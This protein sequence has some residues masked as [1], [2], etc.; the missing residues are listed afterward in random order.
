MRREQSRILHL[1]RQLA[2]THAAGDGTDDG[3]PADG[4]ELRALERM[5]SLTPA[6]SIEDACVQIMLVLSSVADIEDHEEREKSQRLLWSALNA[7]MRGSEKDMS[8]YGREFYAPAHL[9][10]WERSPEGFGAAVTAFE[11]ATRPAFPRSGPLPADATVIPF[12]TPAISRSGPMDVAVRRLAVGDAA[13]WQRN[14]LAE[15]RR[16]RAFTPDI[17]GYLAKAGL[18]NRCTFLASDGPTSPLLF[19]HLAA[20]TVAVLGRA[21]G[22]AMLDQPEEADPHGELAHHVGLQYAEAIEGGQALFNR[23][24]VAGL[25]R[26]LVYTQALYGWSEG[27]RRAV[28]SCID[29]Q[30]LHLW[31]ACSGGR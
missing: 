15:C 29:V 28:L 9:D 22:Q 3:R 2:A 4:V 8:P 19:K 16:Q 11:E 24:S 13:D 30:D 12:P 18:M 23:I 20:T 10:P 1:A 14:I 7:M 21:W 26:P 25:G 17:P 5:I 6:A 31:G 27:G